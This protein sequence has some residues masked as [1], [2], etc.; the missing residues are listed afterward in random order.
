MDIAK[1]SIE[2]RGFFASAYEIAGEIFECNP[3]YADEKTKKKIA[4]WIYKTYLSD[5]DEI[6]DEELLKYLRE[7]ENA[8]LIRFC[9]ECKN[10]EDQ[11]QRT[12][13]SFLKEAVKD[14]DGD[15]K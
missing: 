15:V 3:V 2:N 12:K 4:S 5:S 8:E 9:F 1:I 13:L 10:D 14:F 6:F 7:C 11:R